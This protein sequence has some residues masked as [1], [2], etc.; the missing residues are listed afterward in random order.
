LARRIP[1]SITDDSSECYLWQAFKRGDREAFSKMLDTYYPLLLQYG[2]RFYR[3]KE[4]VKDSVHDLF[5][6]LWNRRENLADVISVKAYLF[7]ALRRNIIRETG[8]QRWFR[9]A[10]PISDD[11]DF[12]VEF[13]IESRLTALEGES[14]NLQK[15]Q[16]R[17]IQLTKRQREAIFLR[18]TEDLPYEEI[19]DIMA[20]N[21]R[22]A[23]N[24][25]HEAIKTIRKNWIITLVTGI[26]IFS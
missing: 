25:V 22:S 6:E 11:Y 14:E 20:I 12:D 10:E 9:D 5:V 2:I 16:T 13:N 19:A 15:L 26:S 21:Y 17:L 3:D 8:R 23:V 1:H 7:Q 4:F 18:Y 24:L